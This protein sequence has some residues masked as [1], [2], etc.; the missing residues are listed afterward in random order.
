MLTLQSCSLLCDALSILANVAAM[1]QESALQRVT[2]ETAL[3]LSNHYIEQLTQVKG[4]LS[5]G[6]RACGIVL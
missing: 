2:A 6:H 1:S 5:T 3:R 4:V